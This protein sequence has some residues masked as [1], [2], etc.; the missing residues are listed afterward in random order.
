MGCLLPRSFCR[1]V[2]GCS[3]LGAAAGLR[4]RPAHLLAGCNALAA[5]FL[6]RFRL[7]YQGA[8]GRAIAAVPNAPLPLPGPAVQRLIR[9]LAG[10]AFGLYLLH[11][12]LLHF[13]S[14]VIPGAPQGAAHRVA[15]FGPGTWRIACARL[16]DRATQSCGETRFALIWC[17]GGAA[18]RQSSVEGSPE[19]IFHEANCSFNTRSSRLNSRS[20]SRVIAISRFS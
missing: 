11:Y 18:V 1:N 3:L 14:T 2:V 8:R 16:P 20:K 4:S 12:P 9:T 10:T 13:F 6:F 5:A 15:V 19:P 17:V 7:L